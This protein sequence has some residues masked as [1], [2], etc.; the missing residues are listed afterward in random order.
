MKEQIIKALWAA[1][2][3]GS[4]GINRE[5]DQA[6]EQT[7]SELRNHFQATSRDALFIEGK[8]LE[9]ASFY[10]KGIFRDALEIGLSLANTTFWAGD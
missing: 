3:N 4:F 10:E 2:F 7:I 5:L 9:L 6:V 8:I 1:W